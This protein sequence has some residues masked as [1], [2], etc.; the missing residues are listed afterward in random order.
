[1]VMVAHAVAHVA[2]TVAAAGDELAG[3]LMAFTAQALFYAGALVA[4]G[5]FGG[6]HRSFAGKIALYF[7]TVNAAIVAAWYRYGTG[8]RQEIWTPSQR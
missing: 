1:M 6:L 7:S 2:A 8:V 5:Q 3:Y 4:L